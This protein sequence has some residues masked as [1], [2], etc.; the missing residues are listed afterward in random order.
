[1][2]SRKRAAILVSGRGANMAALIAAAR[3]PGYPA[4]VALTLVAELTAAGAM[5]KAEAAA[6]H[7]AVTTKDVGALR[8]HIEAKVAEALRGSG[9]GSNGEP[10]N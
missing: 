9:K 4:E 2:T 5:S 10:K 1:M 7:V 6:I 3:R 8:A